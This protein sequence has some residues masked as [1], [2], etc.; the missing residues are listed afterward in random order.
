[1]K[2]LIRII[3]ILLVVAGLG[4]WHFASPQKLTA[5]KSGVNMVMGTFTSISVVAPNETE[6]QAGIKAA[7]DVQRKIDRLMSYQRADS[8]LSRINAQAG[9]HPVVI[10]PETMAV[11]VEA[12]RISQ[13][14]DGAFDIS[15]APLI[16]LWQQAAEANIPPTPA[17]IAEAKA[18]VDYT[19]II[20]DPNALTVSL[21]KPGMKLDLG[22]IAK[23]YAIDLSIQ[24]LKAHGAVGAMVDIGGDICCFGRRATGKSGWRIALQDPRTANEPT[25]DQYRLI[26]DF[27]DRAVATSGHYYRFELVGSERISHIIDTHQGTGASRL[28]SVTIL[29]PTAVVADGLAT[30]VSVMGHEKGLALMESLPDIEAIVIDADGVTMDQTSGAHLYIQ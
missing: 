10:T 15:V 30:A 6:A 4:V 8:E 20:L 26:L 5:V 14:T 16:D 2:R 29:A 19:Q 25:A 1:M 17:Q 22:G 13:I 23:G 7:L 12:R 27:T 3:L 24:A 21:A 28:A 9:G 11:L 18:K